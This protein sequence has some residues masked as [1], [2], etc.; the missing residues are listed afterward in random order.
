MLWLSMY[1][2]NARINPAKRSGSSHVTNIGITSPH[3]EGKQKKSAF[4]LVGEATA[5]IL[6]TPTGC[7]WHRQY[8]T[9][10]V[11][12]CQVFIK[13]NSENP[14]CICRKDFRSFYGKGID[15][16]RKT[17][18]NNGVG[19]TGN[20]CFPSILKNNRFSLV[21]RGGYFFLLWLSM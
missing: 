3:R 11:L 14:F 12:F 18:Y 8:C 5:T 7:A 9:T 4:P 2:S 10:L 16:T 6:V 21:G 20:G 13:Q 17:V 19:V 15:K 1:V